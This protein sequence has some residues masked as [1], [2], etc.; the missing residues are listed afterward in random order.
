MSRGALGV[1]MKD[2]A[3]PSEGADTVLYLP[4]RRLTSSR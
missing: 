1:T 4:L 3:D 2:H